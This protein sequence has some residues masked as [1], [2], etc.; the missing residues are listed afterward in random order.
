MFFCLQRGDCA[1]H[2]VYGDG[3]GSGGDGG[4]SKQQEAVE[5]SIFYASSSLSLS[6]R[7][8]KSNCLKQ[9]SHFLR[10]NWCPV[11]LQGVTKQD[12]TGLI[13]LVVFPGCIVCLS[14]QSFRSLQF[15]LW[16]HAVL[17][18]PG[19]GPESPGRHSCGYFAPSLSIFQ[20]LVSLWKME[21]G[22]SGF[23]ELSLMQGTGAPSCSSVSW[24]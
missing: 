4:H 8:F 23:K 21:A 7:F 16:K 1:L 17:V 12:A 18:S 20:L 13:H 19:F 9:V 3:G 6:S 15:G 5:V 11:L 24:S 22:D 14:C 2:W 10:Q